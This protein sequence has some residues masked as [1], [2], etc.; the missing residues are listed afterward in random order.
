MAK[1][2]SREEFKQYCLRS[3]GFP[4]LR[5]NV[6]DDQ[7][8][9]RID[10]ALN[11]WK[12]YHME[13]TEKIYYKHLVTE[14]DKQNG[15]ITLPENIIGAVR[16]FPLS[17]F[18]GNSSDLFSI[19]YQIAMQNLFVFDS[20]SLVP[21]YM[22]RLHVETI[23]EM[24]VGEPII[25]FNRHRNRL[26]ID[27]N[28]SKTNPARLSANSSGTLA[29][30]NTSTSVI[31]TSTSFLS[32]YANNGY[33]AVYSD[34]LNYQIIQINQVLTNSTMTLKENAPFTN[35]ATIFSPAER[36]EYLLI[37]SYETL[38]PDFYTDMWSDRFLEKYTTALIKRQFGTNLKKFNN[39]QMTGGVM[40]NGQ[41]IYDEAIAEIKE[42]EEAMLMEYSL[43]PDMQVG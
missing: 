2:H 13:G 34:S 3:L 30:S 23:H 6:D 19:E 29:L 31:G 17:S 1:P 35:S 27:W 33:M 41:Q 21:Y 5:I 38:D 25:R 32:S 26:H 14:I 36:G 12:Q 15:Y 16:V 11:Y 39:M 22:S 10:E 43:P 42:L 24:L 40:M 4:V 20:T 28:W 18:I 37:E 7:V 8:E 9:D